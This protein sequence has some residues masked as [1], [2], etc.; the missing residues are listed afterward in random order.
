VPRFSYLNSIGSW[1][2]WIHLALLIVLAI[3]ALRTIIR[4]KLSALEKFC[5]WWAIIPLALGYMLSTL[6]PILNDRYFSFAL[7]GILLAV[8]ILFKQHKLQKLPNFASMLFLCVF[9]FLFSSTPAYNV[10]N[11]AAI[12]LFKKYHSC[13]EL[14]I[15]GPGYYDVDFTYYY[16][17]DIFYNG[18]YHY[19]D[20]AGTKL[21]T[22]ASYAA[23]KEGLRREL[24]ENRILISH[25]SAQLDL[26]DSSIKSIA[27]FDG[28]LSLS[29]P[30]NGIYPYLVE[31]YGSPIESQ[32]FEG[33]FSVYLFQKKAD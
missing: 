28:N 13:S 22:D 6:S 2:G 14:G 31:R 20:T 7:P 19:S 1:F 17:R 30:E 24:K 29:Y 12:E 32:H 27:F 9:I 25:D 3:I 10:D 8:V 11:R 16:N 23:Q 21:I 33:V 15:V 18:Q 5:L 26:D 4:S